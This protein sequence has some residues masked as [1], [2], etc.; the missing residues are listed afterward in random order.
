MFFLI[1]NLNAKY[2]VNSLVFEHS[3]S[4]SSIVIIQNIFTVNMFKEIYCDRKGCSN[5]ADTYG[6]VKEFENFQV[7]VNVCSQHFY[8]LKNK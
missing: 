4:F 5:K 6:V 8:E 3:N 2:I 7:E 1:Q